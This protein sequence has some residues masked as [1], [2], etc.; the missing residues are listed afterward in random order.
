MTTRSRIALTVALCIV[1]CTAWAQ[2]P[3]YLTGSIGGILPMDVSHSTTFFNVLGTTGPGTNTATYDAG[4]Q[5][6]VGLGYRL[7]LGF[8]V[9]GE[10]GYAHYLIDSVSPL[11]TNGAFPGLNGTRLSR[12]S[13]GSHDL[14]TAT[15]NTF[16][17]LPVPGRFVPYIGGGVGYYH[18]S[19]DTATFQGRFVQ[20]GSTI[21]DAMVLGEVGLTVKLNSRLSVVPAYRFEHLFASH[22]LAANASVLKL[23]LRYAF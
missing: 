23:G 22:G 12:S 14:F 3:F 7:P 1:T 8:R 5:V 6:N 15:L 2:G 4:P 18:E 11:S 21:D 10:L 20:H 16:Y 13:G 9:E 17:D 19:I